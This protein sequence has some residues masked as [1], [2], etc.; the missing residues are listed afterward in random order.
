MQTFILR[1]ENLNWII[2][3]IF[4]S[5]F[6]TII[7]IFLNDNCLFLAATRTRGVGGAQAGDR[8]L[9]EKVQRQEKTQGKSRG[10]ALHLALET[11]ICHCF[12]AIINVNVW[13]IEIYL[14][15]IEL[16]TSCFFVFN[17][18]TVNF[19][20]SYFSCLIINVNVWQIEIYLRKIEL[21]KV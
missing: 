5:L 16:K 19:N 20:L 9:P 8:G 21:K 14:R 12:R 6:F 4:L 18:A 13:Q 7:I 3:I 11:S 17:L 10:F 1:N 15:K 2:I